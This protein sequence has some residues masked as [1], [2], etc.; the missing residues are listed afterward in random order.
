MSYQRRGILQVNEEQILNSKRQIRAFDNAATQAGETNSNARIRMA[1]M[2]SLE[3]GKLNSE[4]VSSF[5]IRISDLMKK[6]IPNI[7]NLIYTHPV[8]FGTPAHLQAEFAGPCGK[9]SQ[10][11]FRPTPVCLV[12]FLTIGQILNSR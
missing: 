11:R 12:S 4:F 5:E 9:S 8:G 3:F 7:F 6:T 2:K 1:K 10:R